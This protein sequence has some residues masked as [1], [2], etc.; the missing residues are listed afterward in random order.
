MLKKYDRHLLFLFASVLTILIFILPFLN[1]TGV[2][3]NSEHTSM[4]NGL[5]KMLARKNWIW[6]FVVLI[7]AFMP[8]I[9]AFFISKIDAMS[10]EAKVFTSLLFL[11]LQFLGIWAINIEFLMDC[12]GKV[13]WTMAS[14]SWVNFSAQ[15]GIGIANLF[16][17]L[18]NLLFELLK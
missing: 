3:P 4:I 2:N 7:I 1:W 6:S 12:Y 13:Y 18:D 8:I 15:V 11:G 17:L 10:R 14:G 5:P 16:I 9:F